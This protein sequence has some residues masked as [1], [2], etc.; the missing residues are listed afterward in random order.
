LTNVF[1]T[2][3]TQITGN[4]TISDSDTNTYFVMNNT[5]KTITMPHCL[6]GATKYDGKKLVFIVPGADGS[7]AQT[8]TSASGSSDTF[9]DLLFGANDGAS[10][11]GGGAGTGFPSYGFVCTNSLGSSGV[12][13]ALTNVY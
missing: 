7:T 5:A 12:W 6:N 10:F 11:D 3:T 8:F 13:L 4:T 9:Y 2:Q 1:P